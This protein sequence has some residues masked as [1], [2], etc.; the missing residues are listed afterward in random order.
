M[1]QSGQGNEP[2]LPAVPP[3]Q[4][5]REGVVLPAQGDYKPSDGHQAAPAGGQA[6]GQPWG[7]QSA[8][9]LPPQG[10]FGAPPPPE[11]QPYG[12]P[13]GQT[14]GGSPGAQPYGPPGGQSYGAP[15][16]QTYGRPPEGQ[17]YGAP[18]G[19]YGS[20]EGQPYGAP[21]GQPYG[22]QQNW[23]APQRPAQ[24]PYQAAD[25]TQVLPPQPAGDA[26]ATQFIPP[27]PG[28]A[29]PPLD[30]PTTTLATVKSAPLP[31]E[32][33]PESPAESTTR[34]RAVRPGHRGAHR[35]QAAAEETAVL[36]PTPPAPAPNAPVPASAAN[37]PERPGSA[38][39][40]IRPGRPGDRPPPSEFDGLFR[41]EGA[42][43]TQQLP[44]FSQDFPQPQPSPSGGGGGGG[45]GRRRMSRGML[46]GI[47]VAGCGIAGLAA[48]AALSMG[49]DDDKKDNSTL[50]SSSPSAGE[51][52]PSKSADPAEP[53]AKALDALLADSNN[54]RASVI[55]A[56][57]NIK[58]CKD[59]STAASDLRTAA[60]QRNGLVTR[61]G[62]LSVD[63]LPDNARLTAALTKAWKSSARADNEYAAWADQVGGKKGC[64]KGKAR[65]T[66]RVGAAERASGEATQAKKTASGLWNPIASQYGLTAHQATEL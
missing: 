28:E 20:P 45:G 23:S 54:S 9:E 2:R 31:P 4:P 14:Y 47:V 66:P 37:V 5:V 42:H 34:L 22:R 30:T 60:G 58:S 33:R 25:E 16:G 61:L 24:P 43:E 41:D 18:D 63:K 32:N 52:E 10:E 53:Q 19:S 35:Q 11:G 17:P 65:R 56:V 55:K 15:G 40:A 26:D 13:E 21:E 3:A 59:L 12:P 57:D 39:Y 51:D 46:I 50:S 29:P 64:P 7:P 62:K 49:G 44:Q 48:G 6:W 8:P 1:T 36:P 38:P 27:V